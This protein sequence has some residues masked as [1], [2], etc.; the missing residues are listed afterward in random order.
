[1]MTIMLFLNLSGTGREKYVN[2]YINA[3]FIDVSSSNFCSSHSQSLSF[4]CCAVAHNTLSIYQQNYCSLQC[5]ATLSARSL[6]PHKVSH[7]VI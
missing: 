2:E 3:S 5:R 7:L 1:M 6:L 4:S